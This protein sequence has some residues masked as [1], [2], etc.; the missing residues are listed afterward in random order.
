[1]P[2]SVLTIIGIMIGSH[3]AVIDQRD[4]SDSYTVVWVPI[5]SPSVQGGHRTVLENQKSNPCVKIYI[6]STE[7]W[8]A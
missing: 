6:L 3:I 4:P 7:D 8:N 5:A 2:H 1:M